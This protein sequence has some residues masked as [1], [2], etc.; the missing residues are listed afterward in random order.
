MKPLRIAVLNLNET[1]RDPR[2]RRITR[3]LQKA[4][5]QVRVFEMRNNGL[6]AAETFDGLEIE[7]VPVSADYSL[8]R[9]AEIRAAAPATSRILEACDP[10]VTA[11]DAHQTPMLIRI[12]DAKLQRGFSSYPGSGRLKKEYKFENE[13]ASIRSIMLINLDLF[14]AVRDFEPSIVYA[15]DLDTLV[16]AHMLWTTRG[17]PIVYDAH[18]IYPEQHAEESRSEIWHKFYTKL[19]AELIGSTIGR[20]TVCDSIATYFDEVYGASGFVTVHNVP[21]L[22]HLPP[23]NILTRHN[24]VPRILYH[25]S[26]F[27]YRGLE[28]IID[29]TPFIENAEIVFR[30]VGAYGAT[31]RER[32]RK[33]GVEDKVAFV[34]PVAVT[35]L[36][37]AASSCDIGLS[38]FV[39]VCKNTEFALPNKFFDYMM[40]GLAVMSSDLIE[41]R[42][43][44]QA[45]DV[46]RVFPRPDPRAMADT[47]SELLADREAIARYRRNSYFAARERYNWEVEETNFLENFHRFTLGR[48]Q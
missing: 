22:R 46:G 12:I 15:N 25:G 24:P 17:V 30:G 27:P 26:Y 9:M 3:S 14:R 39:N 40:A 13:V 31:L 23:E 7:R 47:L 28:E 29:A 4:G 11:R 41:M 19:E 1:R 2:V 48:A 42:R 33:M 21:S 36:V 10:H 34:P 20:L 16:A 44:T 8:A 32:A 37:E 5:H 43:L 38:P 6:D 18:E 35:E 45:L